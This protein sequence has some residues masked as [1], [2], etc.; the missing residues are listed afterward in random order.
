MQLMFH[1][2]LEIF[3]IMLGYPRQLCTSHFVAAV[4]GRCPQTVGHMLHLWND[5]AKKKKK[6]S[7]AFCPYFL[8]HLGDT[9]SALCNDR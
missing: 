2:I 3:Y 6:V 1:Y 5:C 8:L 7:A 9:F 4:E